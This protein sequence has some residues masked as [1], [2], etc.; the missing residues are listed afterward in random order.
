MGL[1]DKLQTLGRKLK[2]IQIVPGSASKPKKI[3]TKAISLNELIT[4]VN[5]DSIRTLA[6]TPA[7]LCIPFE[8]IFESAGIKP[9]QN[10][11]DIDRLKKELSHE[12]YKSMDRK[13][14]Q[15]ALLKVL[16]NEAIDVE[17]LVKDALARDKTLDAF[18]GF[19]VAKMRDRTAARQEKKAELEIQMAKISR[20]IEKLKNEEEADKQHLSE[21]QKAKSQYDNE[22]TRT[23]EFLMECR[24]TNDS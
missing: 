11:W 3:A 14:G 4:Q 19:V 7:E 18:E 15:K 1:F 21:W 8:K 23:V 22:L 16:T 13:S 6:Q 5:Q 9:S 2:L 10:G 24:I 17:D 12:K 20:D